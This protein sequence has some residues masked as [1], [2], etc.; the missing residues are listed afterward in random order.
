[1]PLRIRDVEDLVVG[2]D[3]LVVA[4]VYDNLVAIGF[5][6]MEGPAIRIDLQKLNFIKAKI[7]FE[8]SVVELAT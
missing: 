3:L 5:H 7:Y 6:R 2:E 4:A 8:Q 1:M